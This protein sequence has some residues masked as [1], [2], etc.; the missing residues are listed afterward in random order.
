MTDEQLRRDVDAYVDEV[1]EDVVADI[2][3]LVRHDSVEDLA[4]AEPGKPWGPA[5][6]AALVEAERMAA[7]LGLEV[8]D[9]DGYLGFADVPG[10]SGPSATSPRSPTPTSC[11]PARA[12]ASRRSRSRARTAC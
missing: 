6:N 9:L 5:A 10:A 11:P 8:T 2:D 1:W 12:G 3:R 7:R 4:H